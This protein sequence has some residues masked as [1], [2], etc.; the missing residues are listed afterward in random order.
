MDNLWVVIPTYNRA[1]DLL[2]CLFSLIKAGLAKERVIV[3]DN[4]SQ[5]DTVH[6]L[7][8]EFPE[9]NLIILE[10]N[11][12]ASQASNIGFDL[13]LQKGAEYV[14][15]LDSDTVVDTEFCSRLFNQA[16]QH[17]EVGVFSPKIYFYE[18]PDEIW[19]AGANQHPWH[20]G[21]IQG[22][23][24]EKD[25]PENSQVREIDYVWAAAMLIKREVLQ[26]TGGFDTDFFVYYEEV[27]FCLRVKE[28]GYKLLYVPD[29]YIWHKVGS[30]AN[31]PWTAFHWNQSKMLLYRKHAKSQLHFIGLIAYLIFYT[32]TDVVLSALKLRKKSGNR[33][34]LK[35]AIKGFYDG[36][37]CPM[38][39]KGNEP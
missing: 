28:L 17:S 31:N 7:S 4:C 34:P 35:H 32:L 5:D 23:R 26:K 15:R 18:P 27:D 14:L 9:V 2:D 22:H 25:T 6:K 20:F 21:A 38:S 8:I 39:K 19:F 1:D 33:G 11:L 24:Y 10:E 30:S 3:V 37:L 16:D 29:S 12:G 13:A 36:L